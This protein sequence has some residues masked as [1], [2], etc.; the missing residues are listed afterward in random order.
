MSERRYGKSLANPRGFAF[1]PSYCVEL[2][3]DG[4]GERQCLRKR[5]H[6]PNGEYCKQHARRLEAREARARGLIQ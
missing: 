1:L 6:G 2:V 3:W 5:G 4:W